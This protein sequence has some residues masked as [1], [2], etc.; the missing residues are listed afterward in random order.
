METW[1]AEN[2]FVLLQATEYE[3][4]NEWWGAGVRLGNS[5]SQL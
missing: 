3:Q 5:I 1:N 4:V 2:G